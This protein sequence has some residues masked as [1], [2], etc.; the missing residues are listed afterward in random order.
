MLTNVLPIASLLFSAFLM[1]TA[2]GLSG[3]LLP[4]RAVAE[5]WSTLMIS[6]IAAGY[7]VAFTVGCLVTPRLVKRVG[8]VRVFSV[9]ATLMSISL[10][11]HTLVVHPAAW[12]LFRAIAGFSIAGGYMVIE[13]WLNERV[14]NDN[15]G[16]VFSV[17]MSIT[18]LGLMAGQFIVPLGDPTTATLFIVCA[19]IYSL[20]L[21][22]TGLSS[23]QSPQPLKQVKLDIRALYRRS[24]ASVVGAVLAG[25]VS[26]SWSNLGPVYAQ[27][28]ALTTTEGAA[29]LALAMIGGAI[30]QIPLGRA[31]DKVDR[32][33]VMV[34]A[35]LVG[36]TL[37]S[38]A[39]YVGA[40]DRIVFFVVMFLLG[41]VLYP[42]YA[43]NVAHANDHAKPDEFVEVSSGLLIIYGVGTMIGPLASGALMDASGPSAFFVMLAVTFGLYSAYAFYRSR[44]RAKPAEDDRVDFQAVPLARTQTPQTFE[45]D[46]RVDQNSDAETSER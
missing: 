31:S 13:S 46:P 23:A 43:L 30:F 32:R 40:G 42:I 25:C 9:L 26:G 8:H 11:M 29:M 24:P 35:G 34:F 12:V 44:Q 38:V 27:L 14:T 20:A 37:S 28:N 19:V 22:P 18:M 39:A 21:I 41:S 33:Y 2:G 1:L 4:L 5:G 3:Y 17:Y 10:L 6:L 45:L 36:L 16:A 7:A 15:R